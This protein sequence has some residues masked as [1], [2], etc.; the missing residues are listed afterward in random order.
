MSVRELKKSIIPLKVSIIGFSIYIFLIFPYYIYTTLD[1][2]DGIKAHKQEEMLIYTELASQKTAPIL[3][4]NIVTAINYGIER[5][6]YRNFFDN[7]NKELTEGITKSKEHNIL[8]DK[9][10]LIIGES[11]TRHHLSAYGYDQHTTPYLDS[12]AKVDSTVTLYNGYSSAIITRDAFRQFLTSS[13]PHN[14]DA[15]LYTKSL[16]DM[17]NDAG[18][19]TVWLSPFSGMFRQH[20]GTY[21]QL[22]ASAAQEYRY[23]PNRDDLTYIPEVKELI[24]PD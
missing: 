11:A 24:K 2:S 9:I 12:I 1:I 23:I 21:L 14:M 3:Y 20:E 4:G 16:L 19:E 22:L 7:T 8:P 13:S 5:V 18:Y 6:K 10:Y 17:A 15:F